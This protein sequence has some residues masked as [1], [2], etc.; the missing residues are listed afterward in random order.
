M[1]RFQSQ[2]RGGSGLGP[3][4]AVLSTLLGCASYDGTNK[5]DPFGA[6]GGGGADV[7]ASGGSTST[8]GGGAT[9]GGAGGTAS[10]GS[11]A[12]GGSSGTDSGPSAGTSSGG[13]SPATGGASGT[14]NAGNAGSAGSAMAGA[15]AGGSGGSAGTSGGVEQL[16]SQGKPATADSEETAKGNLA[17]NGNDGITTTRW[18]AADGAGGHYFQ[19]DLGQSHTLTKL[20]IS[21]EKPVVYQFKVEGSA[22]ATTWAPILDQTQSTNSVA[23]QTYPLPAAPSARYVRITT[24]TLP[25]A[26]IW[27]SFFEFQVYGQ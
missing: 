17:T 26:N 2:Q 18:C 12:L 21:W 9:A 1:A 20:A 11:A 25:N 5:L 8:A 22:D 6:A 7:G 3:L 16:L 27:A 10:G 19:V 13:A 14:G 24:T 23:D 4:C 15:S